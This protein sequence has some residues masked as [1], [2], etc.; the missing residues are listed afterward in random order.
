MATT[1]FKAKT[2][3]GHTIKT[4]AELLQHTVKVACFVVDEEGIKLRMVD[5]HRR[6]LIDMQLNAANFQIYKWNGHDKLFM[7]INL[8]H[9]HKML[10]SIK[11]KDSIILFINQNQPDDLGIEVIPKENNRVTTSYIKIQN[12]QHLDIELPSGYTRPVIVPANE[13]QKMC[14]E[15]N[16]ISQTIEVTSQQ[17]RIK[18]A[19]D[20]GSV[21]KRE[22][23]FGDIDEDEVNDS[24]IYKEIF[25]TEQL[26]RIIKVSGLGSSLQIYPKNDLPMLLKSNVGSL[27]TI[28]IYIKTK[29]QIE[30]DE[31]KQDVIEE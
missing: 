17:Y 13:Y 1:I 14:K 22:V 4:L 5:S 18:F 12:V 29:A 23:T 20:A 25:D 27:G 16:N 30:E 9:L 26:V 28:S 2:Q 11:K 19:C 6:I 31:F 3:E 7:G 15:M 21:Y 24:T 10:K 8:N